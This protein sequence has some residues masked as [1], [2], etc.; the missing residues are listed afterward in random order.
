[1]LPQQRGAGQQQLQ[2]TAAGGHHHHH[3]HHAHVAPG[4]AA[5]ASGEAG[6]WGLE[7][8]YDLLGKIGEGTYGVVYL[9]TSKQDKKRVFAIKKFKTGRV[10]SSRSSASV[11]VHMLAP[12][13]TPS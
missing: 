8:R 3:H 13:R 11:S 1:V 12:Y 4:S 10:R 6:G 7:Q 5:P 2:H 9:A